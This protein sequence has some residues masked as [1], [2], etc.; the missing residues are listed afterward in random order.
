MA[1]EL[2]ILVQSTNV[3]ESDAHT[4]PIFVMQ[5]QMFPSTTSFL[6]GCS[7]AFD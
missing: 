6:L 3:R 2:L 4:R 1:I 7:N 5:K